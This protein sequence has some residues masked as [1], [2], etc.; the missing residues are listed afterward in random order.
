[1]FSKVQGKILFGY[2]LAS[3]AKWVYDRDAAKITIPVF[4]V[5]HFDD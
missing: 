4:Y 2:F 1:M 3:W 5:H